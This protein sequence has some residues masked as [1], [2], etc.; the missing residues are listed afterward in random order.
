VEGDQ[1][2]KVRFG[3]KFI[4]LADRTVQRVNIRL[5]ERVKLA[6]ER[7]KEVRLIIT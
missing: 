4:A 3:G 7:K 1:K 6:R 5:G 2:G